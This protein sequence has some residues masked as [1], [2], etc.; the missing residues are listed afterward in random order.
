MTDVP[1]KGCGR[2][3]E[4]NPFLNGEVERRGPRAPKALPLYF[5]EKLLSIRLRKPYPKPTQVVG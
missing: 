4:A 1:V 2:R 5:L 3:K